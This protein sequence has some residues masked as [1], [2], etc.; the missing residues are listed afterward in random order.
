MIARAQLLFAEPRG[1]PASQQELLGLA[2]AIELEAVARY[3]QLAALMEQRG[4]RDTAAVFEEMREIETGH[5]DWVAHLAASLGQQLP[6]P[7]DFTWR[8]P[9]ELGD[10]WDDA[11]H[12]TLLTPYRALA[13]A[14]NN[15]ERAFVLYS[16]IA[17]NAEETDVARQAESLAREELAHAAALRV[18]RRQAYHHAYPGRRPAFDATV[19]TPADLRTLDERLA[20]ETAMALRH[21]GQALDAAGDPES[22]RLICALARR[23][24]MAAG[25]DAAPEDATAGIPAPPR[26]ATTPQGLLGQALHRLET[27]S[28]TYEDVVA[29]A[30]RDDLLQAAQT[31][32]ERIVEGISAVSHRLSLI[33]ASAGSTSY[34]HAR[35]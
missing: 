35:P 3:A 7:A 11:Q 23:E 33:E 6:P 10:S 24:T 22:A 4:E 25:E 26:N 12:S 19:E 32:L 18:R 21:I 9:P 8:L 16:Y 30:E 17:A 29:R 2:N 28:E 1:K 34:A 31:S 27:V 15:E 5:V 20:R 14:V 13:I